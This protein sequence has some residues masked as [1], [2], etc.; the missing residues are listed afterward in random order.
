MPW[1]LIGLLAVMWAGLLFS[2][3]QSSMVALLVITVV[4]AVATGDRR[5]RRAV[6]LLTLA[7]A[8][9]GCGYLAVQ[10][11]D[12]ESLNRITS[13][14]TNRVEDAVRVIEE[15]P[16]GGCGDRRAAA[17][18]PAAGRQRAA[19]AELRVAHDAAHGVRRARARSA[20]CSTRGCSWAARG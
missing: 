10:V 18:Q 17:C 19:D 6:A 20:S 14:R 15:H 9:V 8:L 12:G 11:A 16:R 13:D 2:Y 5:V 1:P 3:S 4:L 7:A